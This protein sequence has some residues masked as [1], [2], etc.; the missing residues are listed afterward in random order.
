MSEKI[1]PKEQEIRCRRLGH[2]LTLDYCLREGGPGK[3]CRLVRDCWWERLDI[4]RV[5]QERLSE[6]ELN[7]LEEAQKK[8]PDKMGN[9]LEL[10]EAAKKRTQAADDVDAGEKQG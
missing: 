10:I 2:P 6:E 9:I 3:P 7:A 8:P 4:E 1:D 5:L